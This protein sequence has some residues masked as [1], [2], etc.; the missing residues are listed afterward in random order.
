MPVI[1]VGIPVI[2][3]PA[4]PNAGAR[5]LSSLDDKHVYCTGLQ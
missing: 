4:A 5:V 1:K 2:G 3:D